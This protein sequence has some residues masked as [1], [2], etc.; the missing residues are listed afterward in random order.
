MGKEDLTKQL[1]AMRKAQGTT[2]FKYTDSK[3]YVLSKL[4]EG[5]N[6]YNED[7][8]NDILSYVPETANR[9]SRSNDASDSS[10]DSRETISTEDRDSQSL[11][12]EKDDPN[13]T[14]SHILE[15]EDP[16]KESD[17]FVPSVSEGSVFTTDSPPDGMDEWKRKMDAADKEI[18]DARRGEAD[19]RKSI[20]EGAVEF[21]RQAREELDELTEEASRSGVKANKAAIRV[22]KQEQNAAKKIKEDAKKKAE[23]E[24]KKTKSAD[25]KK[26][27]KKEQSDKEKG[28]RKKEVKKKAP[29]ME[30][31]SKKKEKKSKKKEEQKEEKK[32][33][34][35]S[36]EKAGSELQVSDED[37]DYD[38]YALADT[39]PGTEY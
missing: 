25:A 4:N 7:L 9:Q 21:K 30:K 1:D 39:A 10:G 24:K 17:V 34:K 26:E 6:A 22:V 13:M 35:Y 2:R 8:A 18:E 11:E 3:G 32:K 33:A 15:K 29:E 37:I 36:K 19:A 16:E 14:L 5:S 27:K 28:S 31:K 23:E 20:R 38:E 12:A